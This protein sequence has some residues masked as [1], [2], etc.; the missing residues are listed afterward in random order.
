MELLVTKLVPPLESTHLLGRQRLFR[1]VDE[2]T[3]HRLTLVQAA[4]GFGKTSLLS[5]WWH[6][7]GQVHCAAWLTL[8]PSDQEPVR[9][10]SYVAAAIGHAAPTLA[11]PLD[12]LI[13]TERYLSSEVMLTSLVNVLG[14][15]SE[16][17]LLFVDDVHVLDAAALHT[18]ARLIETAPRNLHLVL[19]SRVQL[20]IGLS[21]WRAQDQL[22]EIDAQSLRFTS[23]EVEKFFRFSG[24]VELPGQLL[25]TLEKRTEGWAAGLK[26]GNLLLRR[27][28]DANTVIEGF[29]GSHSAVADFFAEEVLAAQSAEVRDFLLMTAPLG[30][31]CPDLCAAVSGN[32]EARRV[33]DQIEASGLFLQQLDDQR[34]W[35]RYHHLF[36]EFLQRR[37][38][39]QAPA[40]QA[41]V[42]ASASAWFEQNEAFIEAIDYSLKAGEH[43]NAARILETCCQDMSYNGRIRLVA[44]F[45][46]R[47]PAPILDDHPTVLLTWAWLLT[48]SLDYEAARRLLRRVKAWLTAAQ[49][50]PV[51]LAEV[52]GLL[53]HREMTLAAAEDKL[54]LVEEHCR[55]LIDESVTDAHPYLTGTIYAQLQYAQ[56][57]QYKLNDIERLAAIAQGTLRRSGFKFALISVQSLI[58]PSLHALG[59][60]EGAISAL[61]EGLDEAQHYGGPHSAL[62]A[63]PALPLAAILY[64]RNDLT[65]AQ[66]LLEE[67]LPVVSEFGF[68]DQLLCGYLTQSRLQ[69]S[70]GDR[71]GARQT[72]DHGM[73]VALDRGLERLR[74]TIVGERIKQLLDDQCFEQAQQYARSAGLPTAAK[75]VI[76][77]PSS[78]GKDEAQAIAWIRLAL[79]Q[80][81]VGEALNVAKQ[82]R[83]FCSSRNATRS[84]IAWNLLLAQA[85]L[86]AG[87][88]RCALRSLRDA[89]TLAAPMRAIRCFIDEGPA[90]AGLLANLHESP[91]QSRHST[92][93]FA[94][95]LHELC[96]PAS[97]E[98]ATTSGS[99][100]LYGRL[101]KR[102][103]E[104][105]SLVGI[106]MRNREVATRLGM[107]EGSI[108]WYMQQVYDKVGTRRRL[109]AVEHVRRL[110]L[111]R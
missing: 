109:K 51:R 73:S 70:N 17:L 7:L 80:N 19:A 83:S 95:E 41:K 100:G 92:D 13:Q 93:L 74:L 79:I 45:A 71:E 82:W 56:R 34:R 66:R 58:G 54:P 108:K 64:E 15:S 42:Y 50:P 39:D 65:R 99:E 36:A 24:H 102:E 31:F 21:K 107:T 38:L 46:E 77:R 106:G 1:Q 85:Q 75:M 55:A 5:Q 2:I 32:P 60:S 63:L 53:R 61:E 40:A 28:A 72:L 37:L 12:K 104:I 68:V 57:E 47:I 98:P 69:C 8:D 67:N 103:L 90:I 84:L 23:N 86:L 43:R 11:R 44:Q 110:G 33:L 105:L 9:L 48:R 30:R 52:Q 111:I 101:S 29:C 49:C 18:L 10:L 27:A 76:P 91:S 94:R 16:R 87:E 78:T 22:L 25:E 59:N 96:N 6:A 3:C 26:L 4:A 20:P 35:Y 88:Q 97:D 14:E 62:S 81:H 89:I